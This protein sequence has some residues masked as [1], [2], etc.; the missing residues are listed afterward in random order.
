MTNISASAVAIW[1]LIVRLEGAAVPQAADVE[2]RMKTLGT[3]VGGVMELLYKSLPSLEIHRAVP[4]LRE[5]EQFLSQLLRQGTSALRV[6]RVA[7]CLLQGVRILKLEKFRMIDRQEIEEA[8]CKISGRTA[9]SRYWPARCWSAW[10]FKTSVIRWLRFHKKF[11][12]TNVRCQPFGKRLDSF[13]KRLPSMR[14]GGD[15]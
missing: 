10:V 3:D 13:A 11:R 6:Q 8:M 5:R 14:L 12:D 15:G 7:W 4:L 1:F 9:S 2:S